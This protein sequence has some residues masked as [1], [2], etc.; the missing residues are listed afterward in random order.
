[1]VVLLDGASRLEPAPEER[2]AGHRQLSPLEAHVASGVDVVGPGPRLEHGIDGAALAVGVVVESHRSREGELWA[3]APFEVD[4][5]EVVAGDPAGW[6][7]GEPRD[8]EQPV[9]SGHAVSPV[10]AE[11]VERV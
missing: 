7:H 5:V 6:T 8:V 3:R 11:D 1:S 4:L 10:A 2:L 9:A